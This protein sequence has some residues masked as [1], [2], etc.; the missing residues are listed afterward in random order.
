MTPQRHVV[1]V[2]GS[3]RS[4]TSTLAGVLREFGLHVPAPEVEADASNP[5][6]FSEPRWVVDH[7]DTLLRAADVQTS[8]PRP[9]AWHLVDRASAE[10]NALGQIRVWLG[11]QLA[12][13]GDLVVKDPRL[14]WFLEL[15][16]DAAADAG[17]RASCLTMLRPPAEVAGS[18]AAYYQGRGVVDRVAGWINLMLGTE[19]ATRSTPRAFIR[20]A[21]LL[22]DW[23]E[24]VFR[25]AAALDLP[26]VDPAD[27]AAVRRVDAFVDPSLHRVGATW[28]DVPVP[29]PLR[30][31]ADDLWAALDALADHDDAGTRAELDRLRA[32]YPYVHRKVAASP[33]R[34]I[35]RLV[36]S[37]VVP[38]TVRRG[39]AHLLWRSP[40]ATR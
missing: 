9:L 13:H 23:D 4:G 19:L 40:D 36:P 22:R 20:Y 29:A 10:A 31:L 27:V 12:A 14:L 25:A 5:R 18:K 33:A 3:G 16:L 17:A 7:H 8:D 15:W 32:L 24:P 2:A 35:A 38:Q 21:D 34:R 37:E 1:Y 28:A 26:G 39:V 30:T 6:G 11:T